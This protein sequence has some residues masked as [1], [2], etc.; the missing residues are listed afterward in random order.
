MLRTRIAV[1][2]YPTGGGLIT[3]HWAAGDDAAGVTA[4]RSALSTY[5]NAVKTEIAAGIVY[6]LEPEV[7]IVEDS[8]GQVTGSLS[9]TA[10]SVTGTNGGAPLPHANQFLVR[11]RTGDFF[12]GRELRGRTFLPGPTVNGQLSGV[13]TAATIAAHNAAASALVADGTALLHIY[14]RHNLTSRRV[15]SG[16]LW[17]KF[18]VL[19]SRRD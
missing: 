5:L 1:T 7:D 6:T 16:S 12:N 3:Q 13:P 19:R 14:S 2:G 9:A 11:W 15:T 10:L 4:V 18:A 8:T 17:T